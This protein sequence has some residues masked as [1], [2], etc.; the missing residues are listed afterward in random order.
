VAFPAP[1]LPHASALA[2]AFSPWRAKYRAIQ[3]ALRNVD[4]AWLF[5]EAGFTGRKGGQPAAWAFGEGLWSTLAMPGGATDLARFFLDFRRAQIASS[6]NTNKTGGLPTPGGN[7]P[8]HG[9]TLP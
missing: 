2:P 4:T 1:D 6:R 9:E 5:P 8:Q 7:S 3:L